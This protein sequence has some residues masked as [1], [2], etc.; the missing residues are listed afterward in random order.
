MSLIATGMTPA[1]AAQSEPTLEAETENVSTRPDTVSAQI[2]AKATGQRIEDLS[3]RT[4][5][6]QVFA[7]PDGSWTS[8]TSTVVRFTEQNGE[9]VP[10]TE[11]G[12]LESTGKTITGDGTE[13]AIADG[14]AT[15][16]DG[17]TDT[18]V[19]L[20]T[21][22]GTGENKGKTLELGWEGELPAPAVAENT[23]TYTEGVE[24]TVANA[25]TDAAE[26]IPLAPAAVVSSETKEETDSTDA[27]TE[28]EI[29]QDPANTAS[30]KAQDSPDSPATT[31][32][33]E[34]TDQSV[35]TDAPK[36]SETTQT[37]VAATV[38]VSPTRTGFSHLT[39]LDEAPEGDVELRFPL[40]LSKGLTVSK[41][42]TTGALNVA[43]AEG[44]TVFFTPTPLMWDAKVDE[45]SGLPAAETEVDTELVTEGKT[46]VLVLKASK[47]WL[48]ASD[49][50]YP[51]TIDPTWSG[52]ASDTF[53]QNDNPDRTNAGLE[54]LRVG[55]FNS[56][57]TQARS[58]IQFDP[59]STLT[60]KKITKA[61]VRL[62]NYYSYSCNAAETRLQRVTTTWLASTATWNK[63][64]SSTRTGEGINTQSKGYNSTCAG[65]Y[66]YFP[67]TPI[68]Q[69]WADNPTQNF[70]VKIIAADSTNNYSWKRYRSANYVLGEN[71]AA[72][73][74]LIVTYN[75]YPYTPTAVTFGSGESV[76]DAAGKLWVRKTKPQFRATVSDPDG[77]NVKA[78][79]DM[80]GTST[81][82]KQAGKPVAAKSVSTY[83]PTLVEKGTY[84][85]KAWAN[86]GT[87]RSKAA[88]AA[89][90]FT[91]DTVA[92]DNPTIT[93][94]AGYTNNAWKSATPA[95]NTFTF[96]SNT[97]ANT[98][99]YQKNNGAW[100][101][102][103]A[104]A[105]KYT[106]S[107]NPA[108]ANVLRVKAIDKATNTSAVSTMTFGNGSASI[109]APTA[110]MTT[111]DSFKVTATGP[112]S[113]AGVVTPTVYW[114]EANSVAADTTQY[115][116]TANW[117]PGP[118]A[119][120]IAVG[121]PVKV[122]TMLDIT[123][124][125]LKALGKD[126]IPALVEIQ[127][128]FDYAGAPTASKL[129]C[130][131]SKTKKAVQVTKL[132]HAFGNNYPVAEAG[133]GQ[134]A[135]TTGE[136]NLSETDVTVDA[137]NT[138]LSVSRSYSSYSGI[139]ANSKIFGG[140]WRGNIDGPDEG[141]AELMVAESTSM[142]G[143]ITLIS[144]DETAAVFRQPGNGR[145]AFKTGTYLPANEEATDSGWKVEMLGTGTA[146][147]IKVT[148]EDGTATTFKKGAALAE[149]QK[150]WEWITDTVSGGNAVG[151]SKFVSDSLGRTTKV[152][153][154][155]ET[156]LNCTATTPAAGCRVLNLAYDTDGRL[157]KVTYTAAEIP[158]G[159]TT[160]TVKTVPIAEY[161]YDG[162]GR[163]AKLITVKDSRTGD[164]TTYT[165]GIDSSAGVPL[166]ASSVEK[167]ASGS[168]VDAPT[169]YTYGRGNNT[170]G[171]TDWLE[172]VKRGNPTTGADQ[173]Q[174]ARFVYGVP[175]AGGGTNIPDLSASAVKLW[176]QE[177]APITGYAVFGPGKSVNT[178]KPTGE[179]AANWRYADLQ[180][181]DSQNRVVNTASYAADKWQ[182]TADVFNNDGNV[183]RSYDMRAIRNIRDEAA[184][185][186]SSVK[187]G[188][189]NGH[190]DYA[191]LNFYI[192]DLA[193]YIDENDDG[194]STA[195]D[196]ATKLTEQQK[197]KA[198]AEFLRGYVTDTYAP[199]TTDENGQPAR[200]H[201]R[202][203][204]TS[205]TDL[206]IGGMPRMLVTNTKAT[207]ANAGAIDL[208]A[209]EPTVISETT[210]GYNAFEVDAD[211][212]P[213][214]S[215][216]NKRSGWVVGSPT[217]VST[218][219]F[220]GTGNDI[221]VTTWFDDQGRVKE[222]RQPKSAGADAGATK[223][224]YYTAGANADDAACGNSPVF[225]GYL[226][227][228]TPQG[229]GS[230]KKHQ[231][232]FNIYGQPATFTE[233]STGTPAATR[234]TTQTYRAD[235][236]EL[237]T[238]ITATG[239]TGSTA[240]PA[241]EKLYDA[242]TGLHNGIRATGQPD[243]KWT[244][245]LWGRTTT[246]TNSL[247][248]TTTTTYDGFGNV[249]K[250]VTP[251]TTTEYTY[252]ALSEDGTAEYQGVVTKMTVSGH[253]AA[254]QTGTYKATYDLDGNILTQQTPAGITQVNEYD[255][256]TGKNTSLS[257]TGPV[258]DQAGA[259]ATAP[260]I[261][262][263][264]NRD[265]TGRIVGENT[266]DG[267]LFTGTGTTGDRAAAYDKTYKYDY[268][269][270]L[271]QVTDLTAP[272]GENIND[273]PA[274]GPLTPVTIR[275]YV[276]DKNGNRTSLT[277]TVNGTQT[278]KKTWAFDAADRVTT[279]Y[280]YD[281]LGRQTTIPAADAPR[282]STTAAGS[283]AITIG[284]YN[285]DAARSITRGGVTTT[286]GL[287]AAGR[288]LT[289]A[290]T[291]A[292][293][294][295]TKHYTDDS[296]NPG[297]TT[298]NQGTA[299][300]TTRYESTIGGDLAL[301]ITDNQVELAVNNPHGDTVTTIPLTGTGAGQGIKGWAQYD[302]YGN[303]T[304]D[305][306]NTGATTYGWHGADQRALDASGLI[307]MGARLY[308]SITGLFTSRDPV[309]GGNTTTYA[310]PQDPVGM[311]DVS[312]QWGWAKAAWK[313]T[314]R[315]AGR[316]GRFTVKHWRNGNIGRVVGA[317]AFGA[318]LVASAG[319]CGAAS[320]A[321]AG[322]SIAKRISVDYG[323]NRR[324]GMSKSRAAGH[325]VRG[326][327]FDIG[328]SRLP[329]LRGAKGLRG[330]HRAGAY[331]PR[332][333]RRWTMPK[334][335]WKKRAVVGAY[336]SG[337]WWTLH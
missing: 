304:T 82:T 297:W 77:G 15:L 305:P 237:K 74:Q 273:D 169:Y 280:V 102:V 158:V 163:D 81:L 150:V 52:G 278:A 83:T 10:L 120:A 135:L 45:A 79:F 202:T 317:A 298:R 275:K 251:K 147:R 266:P 36:E 94:S 295:E 189:L 42:K 311:N 247:N 75:S 31:E 246:Y 322:V 249:S 248:E 139:G 221:S 236:Q 267:D 197:N 284:Y 136:L 87:L 206:D 27:P 80:S 76:K 201:T 35:T 46:S 67:A 318:C 229:T 133:D 292:P 239:L 196:P 195:T 264:I 90:T 332:T 254:N 288:R 281:G 324:S 115:G 108:A 143:T 253:G 170:A 225:A 127:V 129:Q 259:T 185:T 116:S 232:G 22:T 226:C 44:K 47:E 190:E 302:E 191:S 109:T 114:R 242:N 111:S 234:T 56:G 134:V 187:N 6:E 66:V 323:R 207:Q 38:Q 214:T 149:N 2:T 138:G 23:A 310:Y 3:Q 17:P 293:G 313:S 4:E 125:Q 186:P 270:R 153:A 145:T 63:Q 331:A 16:G 289:L 9:M 250:T 103:T 321:A 203:T 258:K 333:A 30:E 132:P 215:K 85:V 146:M 20:A 245:D 148:E 155:T 309:D 64:P 39:V 265:I 257:Y 300:T 188:I 93:S 50:Q 166:L 69:H 137:G 326:S 113:D 107:W 71:N 200:I 192:A 54:E 233:S 121:Q 211:Q 217:R 159:G 48:Q 168:L 335:K 157:T 194:L 241:M 53:V 210:N 174:L 218:L 7:N 243:V 91:V 268:A 8:E 175:V 32:A 240:V 95:S 160:A 329:T 220:A 327:L 316:V 13:L 28:S 140:G 86:D 330:R 89:T 301:T 112:T 57:T 337:L 320:L 98:F 118:T 128:C 72:E 167:A 208:K 60:G 21:L 11:T 238:T 62:N 276:F 219:M 180:Y 58:Y 100:T 141:L 101:T 286:I 97:D 198:T 182:N 26:E 70:G 151:T 271:T 199:V 228:S 336:A 131:T 124:D 5:K 122:D 84:T 308:N 164:I 205:R 105:G 161:T 99:Q 291:G 171:R 144:D 260:W 43:D 177:Q 12:T 123:N 204:Y 1:N 25:P 59:G 104:T 55:T 40:K 244:Q 172:V 96:T 212:R 193:A 126:R 274:E 33:S 294:T 29:A 279:G 19:P 230:V 319:L 78:E 14:S 325:V 255:Q 216:D 173:I 61:E 73:P 285:D 51:V 256:G 277:T 178:S 224:V 213:T 307:L 34:T 181:V 290:S 283:G 184:A 92:P 88:G 37:A 68:A 272:V 65:G 130:T 222:T 314:K 119:A 152:I 154:G 261:T 142:D 24:V 282:T 162:P 334:S 231:T 179:A 176:N 315:F 287:D 252:G 209:V 156:T 49:R 263:G 269:G 227:K 312:G 223:S 110:G 165:Y 306:A 41:D 296:D 235:G 18:S 117:T 183:T 106:L 328:F 262:W 303:P 299:T